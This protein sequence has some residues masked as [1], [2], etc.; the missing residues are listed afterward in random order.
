MTQNERLLWL[1]KY[2]L[3][4]RQDSGSVSVPYSDEEKFQ[5]YRSLVNIRPPQ[6]VTNEYLK[7][8]DEY[9]QELSKDR[10]IVRLSNTECMGGN[11]YLW[12]GDI[13]RL[14]ADGIVNAANSRM[15]GCFHPCHYCIDN[16]I[17]TFAGIQ[18]RDECNRLIAEQ[19][20][21]EP[22]G[23]AKITRGFN[24]P[25][26]RI[27]HTVGPII[28][29]RLEKSQEYELASCYK[30][31][32]TLAAEN[33]LGSVA[34]CCISTGVF[35]FPQE[36]AAEIAIDTVKRYKPKGMKVILN[37]YKSEDERRYRKLLSAQTGA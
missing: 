16:C 23:Q 24:L 22:T 3:S 18:L 30:N 9:L 17:H 15:L 4:E 33:G 13:T 5:L 27:L 1:I 19:G 10:G 28:S 21:E 11:L 2:L 6:P 20:H 14:A 31:C 32:L 12:Q 37:V 29:G 25:A 7:M 35:G 8:Q 34:F 26:K 36:R